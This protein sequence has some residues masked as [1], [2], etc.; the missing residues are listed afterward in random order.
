MSSRGDPHG[1]DV[2]TLIDCAHSQ[3]IKDII[4][5]MVRRALSDGGVRMLLANFFRVLFF[6]IL[7]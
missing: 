7:S 4:A 1:F 2:R 3:A 5:D 6:F